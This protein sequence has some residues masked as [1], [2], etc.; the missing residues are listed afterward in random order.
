[1]WICAVLWREW[2]LAIWANSARRLWVRLSLLGWHLWIRLVWY[3]YTVDQLEQI[4]ALSCEA[5]C[6]ALWL[7]VGLKKGKQVLLYSSSLYSP[8][9]CHW[10]D[11]ITQ[12]MTVMITLHCD[13]QSSMISG[14]TSCD[15]R[16]FSLLIHN[17]NQRF[18]TCM[19][20]WQGFILSAKDFIRHLLT[21]NPEERYTCKQA[22]NHPW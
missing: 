3:L 1:M 8:M 22:L 16:S 7:V 14:D 13:G 19:H 2:F 21:V 5:R 9:V 4:F 6:V 10:M 18:Y 20:V 17:F 11:L 12:P 15:T